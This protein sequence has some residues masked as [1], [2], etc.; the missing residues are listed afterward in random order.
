MWFKAPATSFKDPQLVPAGPFVT[1]AIEAVEAAFRYRLPDA[2]GVPAVGRT[3]TPVNESA[4]FLPLEALDAQIV[5]SIWLAVGVTVIVRVALAHVAVV[6]VRL[7]VVGVAATPTAL[8]E[9]KANPPGALSAKVPVPMSPAAPPPAA[10]ETDGPVRGV[11]APPVV[12]AETDEPPVAAV[13]VTAADAGSAKTAVNPTAMTSTLNASR[14]MWKPPNA[15][16]SPG[17]DGSAL[18]V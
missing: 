6:M 9:S 5:N 18:P 8:E 4:V 10:S 12:S 3:F 17:V 16:S 7:V 14:F 13:T 2:S 11:Y 15:R 1:P